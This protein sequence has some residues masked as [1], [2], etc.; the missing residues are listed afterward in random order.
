MNIIDLSKDFIK[1]WKLFLSI[2]VVSF[3]ISLLLSNTLTKSYTASIK[4][5]E[6]KNTDLGMLQNLSFPS[7]N[8]LF[9]NFSDTNENSRYAFQLFKSRDFMESF[10]KNYGPEKLI[11]GYMDE[12]TIKNSNND[13]KISSA[14]SILVDNINV[15]PPSNQATYIRFSHRT[16]NIPH[17]LLNKLIEYTNSYIKEKHLRENQESMDYLQSQFDTSNSVNVNKAF[18]KLYEEKLSKYIIIKSKEHYV[19]EILEFARYQNKQTFPNQTIFLILAF[20]FSIALNL[21]YLIL[22]KKKSI[23]DK[24]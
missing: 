10:I 7:V 16:Q 13:E 6:T 5:Y 4:I 18:S 20:L 1:S 12:T 17:D 8:N 2:L 9:S 19:F 22:Q 23:Q 21:I 14:Y 3:S 24:T 15:R 11:T